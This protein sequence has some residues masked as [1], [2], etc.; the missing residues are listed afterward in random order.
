MPDAVA[1]RI[2]AQADLAELE[3]MLT[4]AVTVAIAEDLFAD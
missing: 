3:A 2:R 1:Q 4:R